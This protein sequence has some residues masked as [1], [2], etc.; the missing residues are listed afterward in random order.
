MGHCTATGVVYQIQPLEDSRWEAFL[1]GHPRAS[2]FHTARWLEALRRTYGYE[3]IAFTTSPPDTSL[4]NAIV[5]CRVDSW[6]TGRRL[7]S[8]P[9]ADHCEPLVDDPADL[10]TLLAFLEEKVRQE[11]LHYFELRPIR[12]VE[13][14]STHWHSTRVYCFHQLDLQPDLDTLFANCHKSSTQRK[15]LRAQREGLMYEEGQSGV[16][17]NAFYRLF[18]IT[19]RRHYAPPQPR[20]WFHNLTACFGKALK[21]RLALKDGRPVASMLTIRHKD[22]L[23]YKYGCSDPRFHSLG[24]VHFL[25]WKAIQEAKQEGLRILDLGRSSVED[26]GLITFKNRW[27]ATQTELIYSR[28]ALSRASKGHFGTALP[29]W[30]MRIAKT[31]IPLLPDSIFTAIGSLFYK[32]VG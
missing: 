23:V 5:A 29:D 6:W 2:I 28:Y 15:I 9:F 27:A 7:V 18:V 12:P 25:F 26:T 8:L 21:F 3:P 1:E 32:H 16:L 4:L 10:S 13:D 14:S 17:L 11:K 20:S 30:K 31:M 19:R 24:G 22:T